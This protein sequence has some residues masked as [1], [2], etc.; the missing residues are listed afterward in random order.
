M[1]VPGTIRADTRG[2]NPTFADLRRRSLRSTIRIGV[3][4]GGF[5][6]LLHGPAI[7]VWIVEEEERVPRLTAS[8]DPLP[9]LDVPHRAHIY[10]T[11]D[12]LGPCRLDVRDSQLQA[13][14]RA[15]C[16]GSQPRPNRHR[17]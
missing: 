3:L 14:Q 8:V 4:S 6:L 15:G 12:Q 16:H 10:P 13:L 9:V 17:A 2:G 11:L 7:P 5:R 1:F